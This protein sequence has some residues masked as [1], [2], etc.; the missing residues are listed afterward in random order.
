MGVFNLLRPEGKTICPQC[1]IEDYWWIQFRYGPLLMT[2]YEIG[3]CINWQA[4]GHGS[5]EGRPGQSGV[6]A[7]GIEQGCHHCGYHP[8]DERLFDIKIRS[9]KVEDIRESDGSVHY[10]G[11]PWILML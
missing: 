9:D 11:E 3:S 6:F 4:T 2:R 1:G 10:R 7:E 5:G 8:A